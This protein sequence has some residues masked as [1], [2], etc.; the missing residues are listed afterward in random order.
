MLD[1]GN[2]DE[3]VNGLDINNEDT[4]NPKDINDGIVEN[5][6]T[7]DEDTSQLTLSTAKLEEILPKD[8]V[9][10]ELA[11]L[12]AKGT[13]A[14]KDN[15]NT[16]KDGNNDK[17]TELLNDEDKYDA[18]P[19]LKRDMVMT[20]PTDE[21]R[22]VTAEDTPKIEVGTEL[23]ITG[24]K[25]IPEPATVNGIL[26]NAVGILKTP[27]E[28]ENNPVDAANAGEATITEDDIPPDIVKANGKNDDA[29]ILN[30]P[31]KPEDNNPPTKPEIADGPSDAPKAVP[32]TSARRVP[33]YNISPT[34][35]PDTATY[36]AIAPEVGTVIDELDPANGIPGNTNIEVVM[37]VIKDAEG[38]ILTEPLESGFKDE[39]IDEI[40]EIPPKI[41]SAEY[42]LAAHAD[43]NAAGKD[44]LLTKNIG[45]KKPEVDTI[46]IVTIKK[47]DP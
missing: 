44:A 45:Q 47:L 5:G 20:F 23:E 6:S 36:D 41:V 31:V 34:K 25:L 15:G 26:N 33:I 8:P 29:P 2:V 40:E 10:D 21:E 3:P 22:P 4:D 19:P 17:E 46:G 12:E 1:N 9:T 30:N 24:A 38:A 14:L 18:E 35:L 39:G 37:L 27:E 7:K 11:Q 32:I 13:N 16:D 42:T 43:G 28:N